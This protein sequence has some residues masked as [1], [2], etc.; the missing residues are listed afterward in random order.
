MIVDNIEFTLLNNYEINNVN[1][2]LI[3]TENLEPIYKLYN[4]P[5]RWITCLIIN[6]L[7][8]TLIVVVKI[9]NFFYGPLR[10]LN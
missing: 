6:Y 5:T 2:N 3:L 8:F 1:L 9:T 7:L 4:A 10:N